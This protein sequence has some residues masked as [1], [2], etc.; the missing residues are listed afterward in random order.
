MSA[1]CDMNSHGETY[2]RDGQ[3]RTISLSAASSALGAGDTFIAG[4]LASLM[5]NLNR[6]G[7]RVEEVLPL[8]DHLLE[9]VLTDGCV[10]AGK[11]C[12]QQG[13]EGLGND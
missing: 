3:Q 7:S 6:N 11:K 9:K 13:F 8:S 12:G 1:I 4:V 5:K 10:L 2:Q